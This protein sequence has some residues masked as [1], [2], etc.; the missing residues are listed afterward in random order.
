MLL[1]CT[2]IRAIHTLDQNHLETITSQMPLYCTYHQ[3]I[4]SP[5]YTSGHIYSLHAIKSITVKLITHQSKFPSG[6]GASTQNNRLQSRNTGRKMKEK[7]ETAYFYIFL[8]SHS[9]THVLQFPFQE[10]W[11]GIGGSNLKCNLMNLITL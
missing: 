9:K 11:N 4:I 6:N 3:N 1:F 2:H 10:T 5:L 8:I 7:E